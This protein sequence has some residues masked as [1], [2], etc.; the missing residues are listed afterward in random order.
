VQIIDRGD[1]VAIET[2][3]D[4]PLHQACPLSGAV[5]LDRNHENAALGT[6]NLKLLRNTGSRLEFI[7]MKIRAAMTGTGPGQTLHVTVKVDYS[8]FLT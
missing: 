5:S 4:I 2:D 1:R 7:P 8:P 3:N 6:Q